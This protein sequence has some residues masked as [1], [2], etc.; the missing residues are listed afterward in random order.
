[1]TWV[2]PVNYFPFTFG[3]GVEVNIEQNTTR[4][5]HCLSRNHRHQNLS[6]CQPRFRKYKSLWIAQSIVIVARHSLPRVAPFDH[7]WILQ[8]HTCF[9]SLY[10]SDTRRRTLSATYI[11]TCIMFGTHYDT[12]FSHNCWEFAIAWRSRFYI[13]FKRWAN[14]TQMKINVAYG[15]SI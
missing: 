1:M 6:T 7:N 10:A 14:A 12:Y 4:R 13:V 8:I 2:K 11:H 9:W 5:T 15:V 3:I